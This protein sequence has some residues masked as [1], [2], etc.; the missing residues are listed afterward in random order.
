MCACVCEGNKYAGSAD[1]FLVDFLQSAVL[2]L[3]LL[4]E[5]SEMLLQD[6]NP[7][8]KSPSPS[9]SHSTQYSN[10]KP[11]LSGA[12]AAPVS[13]TRATPSPLPSSLPT[14]SQNMLHT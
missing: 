11:R 9:S 3:P 5:T 13:Q 1:S 12:E 10:P 6:P 2:L 14:H 8:L 7:S 4:Y